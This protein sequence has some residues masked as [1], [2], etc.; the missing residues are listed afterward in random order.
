MTLKNNMMQFSA[1]D[2]NRILNW[3]VLLLRHLFLFIGIMSCASCGVY[4]FTGAAIEG[5]TINVHFI[6]NKARNAVPSLSASF[7]EKLRQRILSQTS[8]S[9]VNSDKTDYDLQGEITDYSV[10]VASI[11]GT[12]TSTK[13]RLTITVNMQFVNNKNEKNN[14]TQSFS[15]FADFN[16][17]QNIQTVENALIASI[18]DQLADD[19]FN[20][21]FVNW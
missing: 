3:Q 2:E 11:S 6:E 13:N 7:T 8:L 10:T 16:A 9:Q 15:R 21:A 1:I 20:K 19:I 17:D 18:S 14:F 12:E 4:S 5:K